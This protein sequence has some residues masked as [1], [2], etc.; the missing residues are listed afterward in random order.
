MSA[1]RTRTA[2]AAPGGHDERGRRFAKG[3]ASERSEEDR[4]GVGIAGDAN[5][6]DGRAAVGNSAG[7]V[8]DGAVR[9]CAPLVA[10]GLRFSYRKAERPTVNDVSLTLQAGE[11]TAVLGNNGSGKST[12][13]SL[14]LG[15]ARAEGGS[16][17]LLGDAIE[18]L[19]R[20]E[21]ARRGACMRQEAQPS[22]ATVYDEV[23]VGRKPH[24]TWGPTQRDHRI[25]AEAIERLGI[26]HAAERPCDQ[27]SGGERQKVRLARALAQQP[28]VLLLDEPT[29]ALDPHAQ[30]EVMS[31]VTQVAREEGIA[32]AVVMHDVNLALRFCTRFALVR[33]GILLSCGDARSVTAQSLQLTYGVPFQVAHV[34]SVPVAIPLPL[35]PL[36]HPGEH[37][38]ASAQA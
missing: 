37:D 17:V 15:H 4:E 22:A 7:A 12:L 3:R 35:G 28:R 13:V 19:G 34:G 33:D 18:S 5:P 27:L 9:D 2:V 11:V 32:V 16:V 20:R 38:P 10:T 29:S 30:V 6:T 23:I 1:G 25:A 26:A 14:L 31:L 36:D 8:A 24:L 21:V